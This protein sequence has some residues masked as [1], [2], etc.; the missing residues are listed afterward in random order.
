MGGSGQRKVCVVTGASRG[1]GRGVSWVDI[2][3]PAIC[4][5]SYSH[6]HCQ[7]QVLINRFTITIEADQVA[8]QLGS[9]GARVHVT[10]RN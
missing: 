2:W 1:I 4:I 10:G 7:R 3:S 6:D 9:A 8:L 5:Q